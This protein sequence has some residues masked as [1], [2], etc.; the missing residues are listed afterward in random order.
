M[1]KNYKKYLFSIIIVGIL[2]FI[3]L[4][5][6]S[7]FNHPAVD[8]YAYSYMTY[9]AWNESGSFINVLQKAFETSIDF[10]NKWQGLYSSAFFLA[11]QPALFGEQYYILTGYIM[12]IVIVG[13]TSIF[14]IYLT[15]R[16]CGGHTLEGLAISMGIIFLTLQ[17]MPSIVQGLYWFNGT[18]NYG[19]FH[20]ILLLL[21][22]CLIELQYCKTPKQKIVITIFCFI[23]GFVLEGGNHVTA[24]IGLVAALLFTIASLLNKKK[25]SILFGYFITSSIMI[26]GFLLNILAPGTNSRQMALGEPSTL[27]KAIYI[28]SVNGILRVFEYLDFKMIIILIV[29]SPVFISIIKSIHQKGFTFPY[30]FFVFTGSVIWIAIILFPPIYAMGHTGAGRLNNIVYYHFVIL[31]FINTIYFIGWILTHLSCFD[32]KFTITLTWN[33]SMCLLMLGLF[34]YGKNDAWSIKA[35][36]ELSQGIPQQYS[37][38]AY[39]RDKILIS[40]KGKD[41]LIDDFSVKSE[42]LFFDGPTDD[43]NDWR[44]E[45]MATYYELNSVATK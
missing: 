7:H 14:C 42:L 18:V 21:I 6:I 28:A 33:I 25:C 30:P 29:L 38:E 4:C 5:I 16:V 3:P 41:I 27:T 26:V 45:Q 24:L 36:S 20:G 1:N 11:F 17:W 9:K 2:S 35:L 44:N 34:I 37:Q 13:S 32:V 22:C 8:D 39:E 12:L 31:L 40:S 15:K 10:W 19:F 43:P 23:L